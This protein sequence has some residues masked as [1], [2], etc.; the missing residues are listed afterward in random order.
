MICWVYL[1]VID[2]LDLNLIVGRMLKVLEEGDIL[3]QII[4]NELVIEYLGWILE[5]VIGR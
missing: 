4:L 2:V 5:E 3:I 1:G